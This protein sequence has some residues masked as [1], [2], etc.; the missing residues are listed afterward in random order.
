MESEKWDMSE[1]G[2]QVQDARVVAVVEIIYN[3]LE[4][5]NRG[6]AGLET[7]PKHDLVHNV[8]CVDVE[9]MMQGEH[10]GFLAGLNFPKKFLV[11]QLSHLNLNNF[12]H[13]F[14]SIEAKPLEELDDCFP[15]FLGITT[16]A[17]KETNGLPV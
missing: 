10:A 12:L 9:K 4:S 14:L 13:G 2:E 6:I 5:L 1:P 11:Q 7:A 16:V 17:K 3:G 8:E 15:P